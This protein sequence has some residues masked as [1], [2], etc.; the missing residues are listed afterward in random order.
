MTGC[1]PFFR[2]G[3]KPQKANRTYTH[4]HIPK[5]DAPKRTCARADTDPRTSIC[6]YNTTSTKKRKGF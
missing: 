1:S 5:A 4:A 2:Y 6:I 3:K